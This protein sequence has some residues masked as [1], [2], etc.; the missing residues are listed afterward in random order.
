[1]SSHP[2]LVLS[3]MALL[4]PAVGFGAY[5]LRLLEGL[6]R[7]APDLPF[8]VV[9]PHWMSIPAS[10]PEAF[11]VRL[12]G[13]RQFR[14]P[15]LTGIYWSLRTVAYAARLP[16]GT[17]FHSPAPIAGLNRAS[18]TIVTIHDV[19]YRTLPNYFGRLGIR[20]RYLLATERYAAAA[21]LVLTQSAFT[22]GD[23][24]R[25]TAIPAKK[26]EVL[27]P[28]P[29]HSFFARDEAAKRLTEVRQRLQ[30]PSRYWLYVGGYDR[31]KNVEFL[32]R[33]YAESRRRSGA[34]PP[35]VLAGHIPAQ[36]RG[37]ICDVA[38]TIREE[39][40]TK[41]HVL[42]PGL[43]DNADLPYLY[44]GASLLV[45]PSLAEGFGLPPVEAMA[46]GTPLLVADNTS[47]PEVTREQR[48]LFSATDLES[49]VEKL[50][51]AALDE[52]QFLSPLPQEYTEEYGI[53]RYRQLLER[54][55][56]QV[57]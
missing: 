40:L 7:C 13:G 32:I 52:Q 15:L 5:T 34:L 18:I 10:I 9:V 35:L 53:N 19:L 25:R 56:E 49:L 2:K 46:S 57:R 38:G 44:R 45:Y 31:R 3:G 43:I 14:N 11:V 29:A 55:T 20:K 37:M 42:M 23:I 4:T 17:V 30:L 1:M 50:T 33:A 27:S 22:R 28:W 26:L 24:I 36:H 16:Q 48:C 21:T 12:D 51:A 8:R 47:L 41:T 39:G 6:L 54:A